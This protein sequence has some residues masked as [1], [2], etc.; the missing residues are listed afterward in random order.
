MA[1]SNIQV[2]LALFPDLEICE[3]ILCK[4]LFQVGKEDEHIFT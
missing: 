1:S 2:R 3:F 4:V